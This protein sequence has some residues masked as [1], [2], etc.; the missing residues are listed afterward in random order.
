MQ[1]Y[2]WDVGSSFFITI[3]KEDSSFGISFSIAKI[4]LFLI[5]W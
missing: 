4:W 2:F 3:D 1:K 5:K